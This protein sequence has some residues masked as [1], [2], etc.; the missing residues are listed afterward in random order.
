MG[1]N[2]AASSQS[3]NKYGPPANEHNFTQW[4][5]FLVQG[6]IIRH[7]QTR[8]D[9]TQKSFHVGQTSMKKN[10]LRKRKTLT[11]ILH[12]QCN[13][14]LPQV[15]AE[16]GE[17]RDLHFWKL[18]FLGKYWQYNPPHIPT[19]LP[20][21]KPG[22]SGDLHDRPYVS[23]FF[24]YQC[25]W[26]LYWT[27]VFNAGTRSRCS[28]ISFF[29]CYKS[30]PPQAIIAINSPDRPPPSSRTCGSRALHW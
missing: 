10:R 24:D 22:V 26:A 2:E 11:C 9:D 6:Y 13:A 12:Y 1:L 5:N 21:A 15:R 14:P 28:C 7:V 23:W 30:P 4:E 3:T 17:G 27:I 16:V 18:Q 19:Y 25:K 20:V 8:A 29:Q